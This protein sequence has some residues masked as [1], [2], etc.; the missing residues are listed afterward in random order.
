[1]RKILLLSLFVVAACSK[2]APQA[3][4]VIGA[5][6]AATRE[7]LASP[8]CSKLIPQEWSPSFPVPGTAD[9][10]GLYR[11]F[12]SGRTGDMKSGFRALK[13]GGTAVFGTDGTVNECLRSPGATT[14]I[15]GSSLT[16]AGM[17]LDQIDSQGH[18][19]SA[20][21]ENVAAL[22]WAGRPLGPTQKAAVADFSRLFLLLANP[23]HASDYRALNPDFWSWVETNGGA[24]PPAK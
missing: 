13:P 23:A 15:P 24:A 17:T 18:A 3:P 20:A 1:M 7:L 16:I 10:R 8:Q 6:D 5:L 11:V 22:Y 21:T 12:F 2:P 4:T 19:L 14:D 9:R